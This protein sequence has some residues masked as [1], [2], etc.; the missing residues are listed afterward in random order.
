VYYIEKAVSVALPVLHG[1]N[2]PHY[3]TLEYSRQIKMSLGGSYGK[4][5]D[6]TIPYKIIFGKSADITCET[7]SMIGD[8]NLLK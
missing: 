5:G 3:I 4:N 6:V 1:A 8:L 2:T 7:E